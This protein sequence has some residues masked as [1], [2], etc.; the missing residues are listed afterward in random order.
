MDIR[1]T[2]RHAT[3]IV[4][5]MLHLATWQLARGTR[6]ILVVPPQLSLALAALKSVSNT[7]KIAR[8]AIVQWDPNAKDCVPTAPKMLAGKAVRKR[9]IRDKPQQLH[10]ETISN[11]R[12][13]SATPSVQETLSVSVLS[14][15][16]SVQ[17]TRLSAW[18]F[19]VLML[20]KNVQ[21]NL[22]ACIRGSRKPSCRL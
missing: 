11:L 12:L 16:E 21:L 1:A 3:R 9:P 14:A 5:Q 20:V 19:S 4:L 2:T 18:V 7:T 10:A 17:L 22:Q 13:H 6:V 15:L 8:V